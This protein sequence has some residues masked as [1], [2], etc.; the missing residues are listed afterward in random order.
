MSSTLELASWRRQVGELYAR[1]RASADPAEGHA[2]WR[3][4]RDA[5]FRDHP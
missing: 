5:L 2:L 4:G 3:A 1:V